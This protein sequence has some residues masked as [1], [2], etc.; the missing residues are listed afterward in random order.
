MVQ[1]AFRN[2][3]DTQYLVP[4]TDTHG[5][6]IKG[7]H[8]VAKAYLTYEEVITQIKKDFCDEEVFTFLAYLATI[9]FPTRQQQIKRWYAKE[10]QRKKRE[11]EYAKKHPLPTREEIA[12]ANNINPEDYKK[13]TP[14]YWNQK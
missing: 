5:K 2:L 11:V 12:K 3:L 4:N 10:E 1:S 13:E 7:K 6:E 8:L 9:K 14:R